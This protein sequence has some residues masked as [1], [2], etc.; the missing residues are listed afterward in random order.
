MN[1][2][3]QLRPGE[4]GIFRTLDT[5]TSQTC[6][7]GREQWT[8]NRFILLGYN[9]NFY[10]SWKQALQPTETTP[11]SSALPGPRSL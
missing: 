6:K 3:E 4:S 9:N 8:S 2:Q 5:E 1:W 11:N 10:F 7:E